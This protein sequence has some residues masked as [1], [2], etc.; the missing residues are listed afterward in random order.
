MRPVM[1]MQPR[2]VKL[3]RIVNTSGRAGTLFV[4]MYNS[5][6]QP[7]VD[8]AGKPLFTY[9]QT[10]Q[11]GVQ[12]S[13]ANYGSAHFTNN[14]FLLAAGNRADLLVQAPSAPGIYHVM[15]MNEVDPRDLPAS[16]AVTVFSVNVTGSAA[17]GNAATLMP[18][19]PS[20]PP[21]LADIKPADVKST[22]EVTFASLGPA[23]GGGH[24]INHKKF[25]GEVGEL[26]LLNTVEE[27]K[28]V[29][30]TYNAI[31]HP[32]H[33]HIN[34]FQVTEIFDPNATL[35]TSAGAGTLTATGTTA[36]TGTGT[37]FTTSVRP[38]TVLNIPGQPGQG[39]YTV[40][41]VQSDT[42]LTLA[43]RNGPTSTNAS[44]TINVPQ[45]VFVNSP[46]P[47]P[48]QCYLD[49]TNP[50]TWKPCASV[51]QP[52]AKDNIWWDVFPIPSGITVSWA[53]T[54]A[55]VPVPGYFKMRSRFVDYSGYYV[56]HCHILAHEDRGMMTVVEVA[57]AA[58]PYSHD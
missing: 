27:W 23:G 22:K 26:V 58:S 15:V 47:L 44:Y 2:E 52:P 20:F 18:T 40:L 45:Y 36:V 53:G 1:K 37:S 13:P 4:G 33:I 5:A 12:F 21:F 24:T 38:G 46:A 14:Q 29:N 50:S 55:T 7:A 48:G 11:D 25:D 9:Y 34:P 43:G 54:A 31:S 17:T 42:A 49:P 6:G 56:I 41:S 57:P 35:S 16:N 19:A 51:P 32:F 30:E 8:A 10:A 39:P 3:W 28:I